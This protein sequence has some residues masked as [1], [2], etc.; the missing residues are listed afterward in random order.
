MSSAAAKAAPIRSALRHLPAVLGV[1]LLIGAIYVVQKQFRHLKLVDIQKA[2]DA[3]PDRALLASFAWT[4]I[5]YF[6]LTFYDRLGTIY[7]G[8]RV[9]YARA[10]FAS[11]C[12]YALSHNLG[13]AAV[14]GAAVRYRLYAHWGLTPVEIAKTVAFCSLTFGLGGMVL[15]GI[16]LIIEPES[17]PFFGDNLPHLLLTLIGAGLWIVVIAYVATSTVLGRINLFGH[18]IEL[19]QWRMALLQVLLATADVAAT[20]TIVYVLLPPAA[21]LTWLRFVGIY[22]ASYSAGLIATLP[23]G[24]GVFD[25]AMLLG[26]EPYMTAPHIVGAVLIFRLYYYIIPLFLA[27][28]MFTGN[29]L[30]LRGRGV[31]GR[32]APGL[33]AA[34]ATA[35]GDR[36]AIPA[37]RGWGEPDFAVSAA[38]GF[39]VLSGALLLGISVLAPPPDIDWLETSFSAFASQAGAFIPSLIG[40]GLMVVAGGLARRV[41]LA[42]GVTVILLVLGAGITLAQ[43]ERLWVPGVLLLTTVLV[44]PF[45]SAF[46]RHSRLISGP[47]QASTALPLFTLMGCILALAATERHVRFME[48]NSFWAILIAPGVPNAVRL[49]VGLTVLLGLG[50]LWRLLRPGRVRVLPFD[51]AARA[52]LPLGAITQAGGH[53]DGVVVGELGKAAVVFRRV[54]RVL[55]ALGDPTGPDQDRVSAIWRFRD[56]AQQ[57]GCSV[58]VWWAG[59]ELLPVYGDIGL[60]ALPLDANGMTMPARGADAP[61]ARHYL[62]CRAE[63]DLPVLLPLLPSLAAERLAA[64]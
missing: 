45:R 3:I 59:P 42:W 24:L 6:I 4:F 55:L 37:A 1:V 62:V 52:S 5:A 17:V 35:V 36:A 54:G 43:G 32:R 30:M 22:L 47:L 39:V 56:L 46:Y 40:A 26:L 31:L 8:N 14:S 34:F 2:L 19:P 23:G 11:F 57:E 44:L 7:A 28:S 38:T 9:S 51:A 20:A 29:E 64:A 58:A 27:G 41:T 61:P 49:T 13:F 60:A 33:A 48:D 53:A 21:G 12:A 16:I 10:A 18:Q 63:R 25:T 15:A 50:A